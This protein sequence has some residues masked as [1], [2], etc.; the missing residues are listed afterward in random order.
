MD[1]TRHYRSPHMMGI[2]ADYAMSRAFN[3]RSWPTFIVVDIYGVVRFHGFDSDRKLAGVRRAV[4]E[5]LSA[6]PAG[7]KPVLEQGIAFPAE[8]LACRHARRDRSPRLVFGPSDNPQ[9]VFYSAHEGTDA[10]YL[11][12]FNKQGKVVSDER[13][14]PA[15]VES[16]AADCTTDSQ[17]TL[18]ATWC[19]KG[20]RFYDIYVQSRRSGEPPRT[21]QLSFSD[22]DAMSPKIAAGPGGQ[23]TV[24]YYKWAW[25]WGSSRDRNIFAR[26]YDSAR[27]TWGPELE[28]SPHVPEVED[29]TDPDV[30]FDRQG[31]AC[32]VWSYDYHPQLYK[33]PMDADQ[34]TIFT[35]RVRSGTVSAPMLVGATG[36]FRDAID[37]FPSATLDAHGVLWCAW[38]CSE[39]RRCIRLSRLNDGSDAFQ[40]V[41][42]FGDA[43]W[44]CSTPELSPTA[45]DAVLLAW[46]QRRA[47]GLW[48]GRV[49]LLK[50]GQPTGTVILAEKADVLFPLPQQSPDGSYWVAYEK[51]DTKGSEVV[52]RNVTSELRQGTGER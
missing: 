13:L 10:V 45:S 51:S 30:V 52:L 21:E 25:L 8:V 7:S 39:P 44:I 6:P 49:T 27:R 20:T 1:Y 11:G 41:R 17:G 14:S 24:S 46:S 19:A 9:V 31:N 38:D 5:V 26:T 22:D 33:H 16:Y 35:A 48:E 50:D 4:Q 2:D 3:A 47:E 23:V 32:I 40:F 43:G 34:P 37:L 15:G 29:H 18:W 36:Q 42:A 28:I 12:S